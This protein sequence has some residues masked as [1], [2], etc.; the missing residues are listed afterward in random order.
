MKGRY[1]NEGLYN[2]L[3]SIKNCEVCGK[4]K[5][6]KGSLEIHHKIPVSKGGNGFRENL[7][8]VCLECHERLDRESGVDKRWEALSKK[9]NQNS[10][11]SKK[12]TS[13]QKKKKG[14]TRK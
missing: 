5:K 4:K 10:K 1:I 6:E 11:G 8:V 2:E 12:R 7:V 9:K 14:S 3:R 13:K